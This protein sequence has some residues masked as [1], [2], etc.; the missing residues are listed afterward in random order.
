MRTASNL[1]FVMLLKKAIRDSYGGAPLLVQL[2]TLH[3][4]DQFTAA[5]QSALLKTAE[6]HG[7]LQGLMCD[8]V[9]AAKKAKAA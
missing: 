4:S 7:E 2:A 1:R 8:A 3:A 5:E 6:A 9:K